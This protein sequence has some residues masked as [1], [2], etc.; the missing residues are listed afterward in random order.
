MI[1]KLIE[2]NINASAGGSMGAAL[3]IVLMAFVGLLMTYYLYSV[4]RATKEARS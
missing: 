1:A 4:A 2:Q 3:T